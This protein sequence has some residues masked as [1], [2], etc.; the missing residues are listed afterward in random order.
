[1]HKNIYKI[2]HILLLSI[3]LS[4]TPTFAKPQKTATDTIENTSISFND[5]AAKTTLLST[6]PNWQPE[7][8]SLLFEAYQ[9][10][11]EYQISKT[12][13]AWIQNALFIQ[14]FFGPLENPFTKY[15]RPAKVFVIFKKTQNKA[16]NFEMAPIIHNAVDGNYYIFD[17][18]ETS[19]LQ[20]DEWIT[21]LKKSH[22][23]QTDFV[24]N[25]CPGYAINPADSCLHSAYQ[26]EA[27]L[28]SNALNKDK[29]IGSFHNPSAHRDEHESWRTKIS[30]NKLNRDDS[31]SI[32]DQ[33]IAWTDE[34]AKKDLL[35]SVIS[36]PNHQTIQAAFEKIRDLRYARDETMPDFNRRLTWLYPDD[37][38]WTR[39]AAI[40]KDFF[41][42]LNNTTHV[43]PRPSKLFAF[44][45]LCVNTKNTASGAVSWWYHTAPIVKDAETNITYVLDPSVDPVT[46]LPL[47]EWMSRVAANTGKCADANHSVS[48]FS[49]CNGYGTT[50]YDSCNVPEKTSYTTELNA[51]REQ[52]TYRR[53]EATRQTE[54]GR[55]IE[56]VLGDSPPWHTPLTKE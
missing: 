5:A 30:L 16:A 22:T 19:P 7:T 32:Y 47:E 38:C 10:P 49:I 6:V 2:S 35:H 41:G 25:I 48:Q 52:K 17:A 15:P 21:K 54:L 14:A 51:M 50:P 46:A 28:S 18:T 9:R 12:N 3:L 36:W 31:D 39:A 24:F 37:G 42:P 45:D 23:D 55:H 20:L 8:I 4:G 34:V 43:L 11:E 26:N 53:L 40:I 44:G 1:M 13:L 33:S 56:E 27:A 29:K